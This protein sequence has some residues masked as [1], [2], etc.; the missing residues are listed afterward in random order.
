[1]SSQPRT[2]STSPMDANGVVR[3]SHGETAMRKTS[4]TPSN[5]NRE[6][7]TCSRS[8]QSER[9]KFF[10]WAD[11]PIFF[12]QQNTSA[13]PSPPPAPS[14]P[15]PSQR[16][17]AASFRALSTPQKSPRKSPQQ[18]AVA[19]TDPTRSFLFGSQS[20]QASTIGDWEEIS[21]VVDPEQSGSSG[22]TDQSLGVLDPRT[23]KK[24][25]ITSMEQPSNVQPISLPLT[26]PQTIRLRR[27]ADTSFGQGTFQPDFPSTPTRNKGKEREYSG[28]EQTTSGANAPVPGPSE[29][30]SN[31]MESASNAPARPSSTLGRTSSNP[32]ID[33]RTTGEIM[34]SHIESLIA[35]E[36]PSYVRKME[37]KV[38]ALDLSN[39]AK[40]KYLED[41]KAAKADAESENAR[42]IEENA[43]LDRENA[44]LRQAIAD[45]QARLRQ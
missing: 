5:P 16:Q 26:P 35:L 10:Y 33:H 28:G 42:L 22:S 25:R 38:N 32:F 34:A 14:V 19:T 23:P 2:Q 13:I 40:A 27:H 3:C 43:G 17:R 36:S 1:M 9:C 20:S 11:D 45:L 18:N 6:F 21:P 4:Q 7:Y 37:R 41:L 39:K 8:N 12:R 15:P 29:T 31:T 44:Q 24:P 30:G